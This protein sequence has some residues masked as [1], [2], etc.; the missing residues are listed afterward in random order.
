MATNFIRSSAMSSLRRA[1]PEP[2][3]GASSMMPS[4]L[5][6][7]TG[8]SSSSSKSCNLGITAVRMTRLQ[9][10]PLAIIAE[11][12]IGIRTRV[13][14]GRRWLGKAQQHAPH[15]TWREGLAPPLSERRSLRSGN[16]LSFHFAHQR[17][18]VVLAVAEERHPE[19]VVWH[20]GDPVGLVFKTHAPVFQSCVRRLDI[21]Y[22]E[23]QYRARMI[24]LGFL[25][26]VQH[27]A[28]PS[29]IEKRQSGRRFEQQLQS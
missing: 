14:Q 20:A 22:R 6:E 26:A 4:P 5:P 15:P 24:E 16:W 11:D 27:Q 13:W 12:G 17:E 28:N 25:R 3:A 29:T 18:Q 19:I 7:M 9:T 21:G 23:I 10:T 1:A 8:M 2:V